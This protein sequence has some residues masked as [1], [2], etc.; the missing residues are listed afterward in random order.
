MNINNPEITFA[1]I[2]VPFEEFVDALATKV[3]LRIY[4]I[5]K[6]QLEISQTKAY[7][8]F[9]RAAVDRWIKSGQLQPCRVMPGKKLYR[10]IELQ[11]LASV[12]QNY[13]IK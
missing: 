8:M 5:E 7:R 6:G 10:L 11:K 12:K 1:N 2:S 9:G 13:L 3:A 4:Q